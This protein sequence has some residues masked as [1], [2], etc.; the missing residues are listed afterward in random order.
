MKKKIAVLIGIAVCA[1]LLTSPVLASAG[2]SK[3]YGNANG[4]DTLDMRDVTY[5]KLV[6]FGKKPATTFAD[7]NNDG[8]I[9]MLDIGQTK[10]VILA[11]EKRLTLIDQAD[12]TMTINKPVERVVTP[13]R[14]VVRAFIHLGVADKLVGV[15]GFKEGGF[16][17]SAIAHPELTTELP[18][19]GL[20]GINEELIVS[21]EP[22]VIFGLAQHI[23]LEEKTGI[24]VIC[25]YLEADHLEFELYRLIGKVM[26]KEK[27]AEELISYAN[28]KLLRVT[29]VTSQIPDSKKPRVYMEVYRSL[30]PI[31]Y[32]PIALAGGIDVAEDLA[33]THPGVYAVEVS[34]EQI[35]AWNPDIIVLQS[36][37]VENIEVKLSDPALQTV[38]A[39]KNRR[40]YGTIGHSAGWDPVRAITETFYMAKL[41]HPEEFKYLDVE[42]EGNEILKRAYGADDLYTMTAEKRNLYRWE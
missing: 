31:H 38:N 26:G 24:P 9:S 27:E 39:I 2:Y 3:I 7:A 19:I 32:D 15:P 17:L 40:I 36:G 1:M 18:T 42:K 35:V 33:D 25:F 13:E 6:I 28:G 30:T 21:L 41:F 16:Y 34:K 37:S 8:K 23:Y 4:D 5:I 11:K 14:D 10:L 20:N 12:R 29:E 22:D